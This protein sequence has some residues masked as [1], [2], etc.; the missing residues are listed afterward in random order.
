MA[1]ITT[2]TSRDWVLLNYNYTDATYE[3][4]AC[5]RRVTRMRDDDGLVYPP[6]FCPFCLAKEQVSVKEKEKEKENG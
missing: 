1:T 4:L 3:H 6:Q 2:L 5:N